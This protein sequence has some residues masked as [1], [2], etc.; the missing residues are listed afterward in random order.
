MAGIEDELAQMRNH[1]SK[2]F[3]ESDLGSQ[4]GHHNLTLLPSILI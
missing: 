4:L 2:D 3:S 1:S